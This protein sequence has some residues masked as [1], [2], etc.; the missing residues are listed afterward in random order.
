MN[1]FPKKEKLCGEK[2]INTLFE[3]GKAFIE[4]PLRV[5]YKRLDSP[6]DAVSRVLISVPKKK[7]KKSNQRNLL[8][9]RIRE[10]YRLNKESFITEL[11]KNNIY[12]HMALTY[13]ADKEYDFQAI[14]HAMPVIFKK[15]LN[16]IAPKND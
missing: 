12:L 7:I 11:E 6:E 16:K 1:N 14:N 9:R 3:Q 10:A 15:I 4:Y 5:V 2:Q 8:K 13:V